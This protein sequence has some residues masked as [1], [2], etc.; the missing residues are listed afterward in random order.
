MLAKPTA[1]KKAPQRVLEGWKFDHKGHDAAAAKVGG[2]KG[3]AEC[4]DC[5]QYKPDGTPDLR[6]GLEHGT[7]C[8][9]CHQAEDKA[10]KCFAQT[11]AKCISCHTFPAND[12][13]HENTPS[14]LSKPS[15]Y[16]SA[17][18]HGEH[19]GFKVA[20]EKNCANCHRPQAPPSAVQFNAH[21]SCWGCHGDKGKPA[22]VSTKLFRDNCT[23]C[24]GAAKPKPPASGDPFRLGKFD[25]AA[26]Q[27]H[28]ATSN[29]ASCTTCHSNMSGSDSTSVPRP[30]MQSCLKGCHD[31]S[32]GKAFSAVGTKCTTCHNSPGGLTLP[33]KKDVSFSHTA[34]ANRNTDVTN[35]QSCHSV[36]GDG[37]VMAPNT[38]KD[39]MPCSNAGCHQTEFMSKTTKICFVCHE[40]SAVPWK[41]LAARMQDPSPKPEFF[42]NIS[43]ASH[44]QKKGTNN[45]A[46]TDCHGDKLGGGK[47]PKDHQ[48]C[49]E[50]HGKGPPAHGMN[51]CGKCHQRDAVKKPGASDWSV[52]ATFDHK[53][54]ANDSTTRKTTECSSCHAEIAKSTSL[55]AMAKPKMETCARCHNGKVSFKTTGFDCAK[56]HIKTKE[57]ST[58]APTSSLTSGGGP[59][60]MLD[61]LP[62][63]AVWPSQT[64][65]GMF[66]EDDE[67]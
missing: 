37:T 24:H 54:H 48:A 7:R 12:P 38:G 41:K 61:P 30:S 10:T 31:G 3:K 1:V 9:K 36:A 51:E 57:P 56:C 11:K 8:V 28:H 22:T 64:Q 5:H 2:A 27:K 43:H 45:A 33:V 55:A 29:Q 6:A 26:H 46:C 35:C 21:Q 4:K 32:R 59:T 13:C 15:I 23:G 67:R 63:L 19:L 50:C 52:A 65:V 20:I 44:L 16:R 62:P 42:E 66:L 47:A 53:R 17:F 49:A 40:E 14:A 58:P 34:H 18:S 25:A 60:A 39:H